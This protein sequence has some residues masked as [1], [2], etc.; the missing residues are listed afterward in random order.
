[1]SSK[2]FYYVNLKGSITEN[3]VQT[4]AEDLQKSGQV[5]C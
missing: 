5:N 3:A 4:E 1:M 2:L